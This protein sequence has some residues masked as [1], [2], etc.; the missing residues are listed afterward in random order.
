MTNRLFTLP[1]PLMILV[2]AG[3]SIEAK[4]QRS[5]FDGLEKYLNQRMV[6]PE[7]VQVIK[8][9]LVKSET[10]D[11][12]NELVVWAKAGFPDLHENGIW[13]TEALSLK[14]G[15]VTSIHYYFTTSPPENKSTK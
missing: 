14:S 4:A 13:K 1:V 11:P 6:G 2:L 12:L 3:F 5:A 8:Q 10:S 15:V 7:S 9:H